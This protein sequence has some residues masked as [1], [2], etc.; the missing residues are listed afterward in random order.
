MTTTE[1]PLGKLAPIIVDLGKQRRKALKGLKRGTGKLMDEV[2]QV[3]GEVRAEMG[4]DAQKVEVL[5][6]VLIYK[7][8]TSRRRGGLAGLL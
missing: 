1:T 5:P 3:L 6:I 2:E 8:K 7:R 4:A